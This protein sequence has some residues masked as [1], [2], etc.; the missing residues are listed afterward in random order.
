[1]KKIYKIGLFSL[2][3]FFC[4]GISTL[5]IR[6]EEELPVSEEV[7]EEETDLE[8]PVLE[9][10]VE[11]PM[12]E[13]IVPE[14]IVPIEEQQEEQTIL[15]GVQKVNDYFVIYDDQGNLLKGIQV[16]HGHAYYLDPSTGAIQT[17]FVY[18]QGDKVYYCDEDGRIQT[19]VFTIGKVTVTT[20]KSGN[21]L[22]SDDGDVPYYNQKDPRWANVVVGKGNIGGTGCAMNVMTSIVNYFKGTDYTPD[23]IARLMY[24]AGYYNKI[25]AG[26]LG[27]AWPYMA[28]LFDL[29]FEIA[30]TVENATQA[31]KKGYL[32]AAGLGTSIFI[33][34]P[35]THELLFYG[36]NGDGKTNLYDPN[37]KS[38]NKEYTLSYL[39][40]IPSWDP[41]YQVDGCSYFAI[42]LK[43]RLVP[44]F[45]MT[46]SKVQASIPDQIFTGNPIE[47]VVKVS[48]NENTLIENKDYIIIGFNQN[49]EIGQASLIIQ[50]IHNYTGIK[51]IY[52][53]IIEEGTEPIVPPTEPILPVLKDGM[54]VISAI[55][56]ENY[57]LNNSYGSTDP[58][59][60]YIAYQ[61]T[62]SNNQKFVVVYVGEGL[63]TI[64]NVASGMYLACNKDPGLEEGRIHVNQVSQNVSNASLWYIKEMD[65]AYVICSGWNENYV[66]N[67]DCEELTGPREIILFE[68]ID[69]DVYQ[70]WNFEQI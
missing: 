21:I 15:T 7:V 36:Y 63:Y 29:D 56:N 46:S 68:N 49:I 28:E 47:P 48:R 33:N 40:S 11:M 16:Y 12:E 52:F 32:I 20:D 14:E 17:G 45:T 67:I 50:G 70:K 10:E 34:Y 60:E 58:N 2:A 23:Y 31:L 37:N 4:M 25:V 43:N 1:M 41:D 8:V 26:T 39:Y 42:G 18:G 59:Q 69:S 65:G 62:G 5:S 22:F 44:D 30:Y 19:G 3:T 55:A 57:C 6:A 54:Y 53:N 66:L 24:N 13:E 9:E 51:T 35:Y 38:L 27:S 64:Q 61:R